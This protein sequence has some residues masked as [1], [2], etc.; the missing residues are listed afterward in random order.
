MGSG[1]ERGGSR[2]RS[3]GVTERRDEWED[4]AWV[5]HVCVEQGLEGDKGALREGGLKEMDWVL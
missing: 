4:E 3:E 1:G 2:G 5:T